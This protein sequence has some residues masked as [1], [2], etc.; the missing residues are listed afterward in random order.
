MSRTSSTPSTAAAEYQ[1]DE[2]FARDL[3]DRDPLRS[4]RERFLLPRR[5]NGEPVIYFGGNSLG[6]QPEA[7][8]A[9]LE[10]ELDDWAELGVDAHLKGA[11]PWYAYHEAFAETGGR[12]VGALMG[13]DQGPGG[14][15]VVMMN[16]LTVNLHLMMTTFYRP[17]PDRDRIVMEYPA[18]PSD[19][20]AVKTHLKSRGLDPA[21]ALVQVKPRPG[22]HTIRSEDLERLLAEQGERIALVLLPGVNFFTGQVFDMKR[23]T[24]AAKRHGCMVG[25]DLAHAAG[26]VIT[27][28]HDWDVDFACWC[29][30]KYLNGGPGAVGGCFVHERH[31]RD[32]DLPRLAGWWGNDP[33]TRFKL[34]LEPD[35]IP[36]PGAAGWQISNPPI[37]SMAPLR[38][39]LDLFDEAGMPALRAKSKLLTGYLRYLIERTADE[40]I[41]IITPA[42]PEAGGCQLSLLVHDDPQSRHEALVAEGVV[43]DFRQPNV[44]RVAPVPLYNT[45]HEVWQFARILTGKN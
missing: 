5:P 12:L 39:S 34:H 6:L 8:R 31:G 14:A 38:V 7:V 26:N 32:L 45:F 21:L 9:A 19:L 41:E 22:E 25:W 29:S 20:Y 27:E 2:S 35:F 11:I 13:T 3:D 17:T 23:I 30:Y 43:C 24:A 15:E 4:Y 37:L 36:Q 1:P 16:S 42:A 33:E 28:L 10:Q 44:I 18:F 40:R